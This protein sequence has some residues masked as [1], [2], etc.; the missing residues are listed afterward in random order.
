MVADVLA[1]QVARASATM[2]F[3]KLNWIELN[4]VEIGTRYYIVAIW[5]AAKLLLNNM[6][7]NNFHK[8]C[9]LI[10]FGLA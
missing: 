1:T 3:I 8:M 4:N 6:T 9:S 10:W 5:E 2:M 7:V